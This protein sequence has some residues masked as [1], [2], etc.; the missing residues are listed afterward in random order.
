MLENSLIFSVICLYGILICSHLSTLYEKYA[1]WD[2]ISGG[3]FISK[4][5]QLK[6]NY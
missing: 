4:T 6:E 3:F 2:N 1:F 5:L